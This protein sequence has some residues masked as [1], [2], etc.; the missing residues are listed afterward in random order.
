[1]P[2]LLPAHSGEANWMFREA[3]WRERGMRQVQREAA[4]VLIGIESH[5]RH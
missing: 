5:L 1:V 2:L 3:G 4:A